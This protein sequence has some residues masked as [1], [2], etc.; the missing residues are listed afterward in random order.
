MVGCEASL[1]DQTL[2]ML[3]GRNSAQQPREQQAWMS[4][5]VRGEQGRILAVRA[6]A[7]KDEPGE[8]VC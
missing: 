4:S 5:R 8:Q 1:A 7:V 2:G 3:C 6:S